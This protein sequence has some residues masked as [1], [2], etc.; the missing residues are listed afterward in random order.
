M[1]VGIFS[2]INIIYYILYILLFIL[3]F[4]I[5]TRLPSASPSMSDPTMGLPSS[6]WAFLV[7]TGRLPTPSTSLT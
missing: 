4:C 1:I 6:S 5:L 3:I 2:A 7:A